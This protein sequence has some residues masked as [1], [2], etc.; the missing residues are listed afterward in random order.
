MASWLCRDAIVLASAATLAS[1]L[2]LAASCSLHISTQAF[3]H[4][5][6]SYSKSRQVQGLTKCTYACRA[7]GHLPQHAGCCLPL[8]S[9]EL[10]LSQCCGLIG[11][12]DLGFLCSQ[13]C[14][15]VVF[16][17]QGA[18]LARASSAEVLQAG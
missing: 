3:A 16:V 8:P 1:A 11:Q 14:C 7:T 2:L 12:L 18:L 13:L 4:V 17:S 15:E 6:A 5:T 9:Q 10:L